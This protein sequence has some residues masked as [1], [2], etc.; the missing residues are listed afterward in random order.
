MAN[1]YDAAPSIRSS[2]SEADCAPVIV[3]FVRGHSRDQGRSSGGGEI[4]LCGTL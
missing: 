2:L 1:V 3:I 4:D